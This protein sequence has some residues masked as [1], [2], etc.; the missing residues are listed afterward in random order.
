MKL[1]PITSSLSLW[2]VGSVALCLVLAG[3]WRAVRL[4][5]S[6]TVPSVVIGGTTEAWLM[7]RGLLGSQMFGD[8][9]RHDLITPPPGVEVSE[10]LQTD[11]KTGQ[12]LKRL[13]S[14]NETIGGDTVHIDVTI[15]PTRQY[16]IAFWLFPNDRQG[17]TMFQ[18][19]L[20]D[21]GRALQSRFWR[22]D[23]VPRLAGGRN[24][25]SDLYPDAIPFMAFLRVLGTPREGAVGTLNQQITEYS[26]VGQ[27][28]VATSIERI[29]VPAGDFSALKV[30]AQVDIATVMPTWPRFILSVIKPV[31]PKNTLYFEAATPYRLL[32]QEGPTYVGGPEATTELLRFYTVG[33]EQAV[34]AAPVSKPPSGPAAGAL[35]G[36]STD[37]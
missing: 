9:S 33:A 34:A 7:S 2:L 19:A 20:F 21:S 14:W 8:Q 29:K 23:A 18:W 36:S 31:V 10:T 11:N 1:A 30:T 13:K 3:L 15:L 28:V 6:E 32:K 35:P 4:K 16:E 24:L 37:K 12:E 17:C 22:N 27:D 5:A 25:P 26:Y